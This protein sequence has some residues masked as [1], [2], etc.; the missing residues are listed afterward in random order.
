MNEDN[1]FIIYIFIFVVSF[2][3]ICTI[4]RLIFRSS[5]D[6]DAARDGQ[7]DITEQLITSQSRVVELENRISRINEISERAA[8]SIDSCFEASRRTT[9]NIERL[10]VITQSLEKIYIDIRGISVLSGGG[11]SD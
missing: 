8:K 4:G 9:E 5:G 1:R 3:T 11:A 2:I 6:I 7:R 10:R